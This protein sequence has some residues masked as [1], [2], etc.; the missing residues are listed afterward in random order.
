MLILLDPTPDWAP[1]C[2]PLNGFFSS[3]FHVNKPTTQLETVDA[4]RYRAQFLILIMLHLQ[5]PSVECSCA[6]PAVPLL[7]GAFWQHAG[8]SRATGRHAST[9]HRHAL[10][11]A[12]PSDGDG[13]SDPGPFLSD[14]HTAVSATAY[15]AEV[16]TS[17]ALHE[18]EVRWSD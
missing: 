1:G 6:S 3:H 5:V 12:L 8:H 13:P 15:S 10:M 16:R 9:R 14:S 18:Q 4:D 17:E 2:R 7:G 11:R